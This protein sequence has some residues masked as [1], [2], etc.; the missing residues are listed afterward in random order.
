MICFERKVIDPNLKIL[1]IEFNFQQARTCHPQYHI[2]T[3][4][5]IT[6]LSQLLILTRVD[7]YFFFFIFQMSTFLILSLLRLVSVTFFFQTKQAVI[8]ASDNI[9]QRIVMFGYL[10]N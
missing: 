3:S 4:L 5:A 9:K 8:I 10:C 1:H 2:S 7:I 6:P